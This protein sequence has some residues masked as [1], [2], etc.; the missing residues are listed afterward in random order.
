MIRPVKR[1]ATVPNQGGIRQQM[2]SG[3][4]YYHVVI[5]RAYMCIYIYIYL[6]LYIYI[7]IYIYIHTCIHMTNMSSGREG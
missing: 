6:S 5:I 7:Y 2:S 1:E 3:A 4:R